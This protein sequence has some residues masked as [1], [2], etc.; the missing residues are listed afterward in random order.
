MSNRRTPRFALLASS[1]TLA[2]ALSACGGG[3]SGGNT[4]PEAPPPTPPAPPPPPAVCE[5]GNATNKGGDLPCTYRYNGQGDNIL[6]PVNADLAHEAGFTG[7][8]V[9]VG[10][11]DDGQVEGYSALDG[12]VS[13]YRDYTGKADEADPS[14]KYGHGA[15]VAAILGGN[16]GSNFNG[17]VAPDADLHWARICYDD[18]CMS[19]RAGAAVADM[20]EAGVRLFN[21]S[22]GGGYV[23]EASAR[24]SAAAWARSMGDVLSNDALI[25]HSAG[26]ESTD[27]PGNMGHVPRFFPEFNRNWL[28]VAAVDVD[29]DGNPADLSDYSNACG[30]AAEWCVVAPGRVNYPSIPDTMWTGSGY[31]TSFA[32]PIVTGT[33]A[34]VWQAFPWMSASNVQQTILTTATDLGEAG[35]DPIYGWGMVNADKA[36]RGPGQFFGSHF[37]ANVSSGSYEFANDIAGD[38]GLYKD[39]KGRLTLTGDNT[40]SGET[41]V[42]DGQLVVNNGTPGAAEVY[43]GTLTIGGNVGGDFIAGADGTTEIAIGN[44]LD[45]DGYAVLDGTLRLLNPATGYEPGATETLLT[46]VGVD[47]EFA[48]VAFGSGFFWN[49]TVDYS[50]TEVVASLERA[51]AQAV[52]MS[53]GSAQRVIEGAGQADALLGFLDAAGT[54]DHAALA[55]AAARLA[56]AQTKAEAEAALASLTGEVHGTAR[57]AAM[58]QAMS[59]SLLFGDR[60]ANLTQADAGVW[61][62]AS[63]FDGEFDRDGFATADVRQ[64]GLTVGVDRSVGES[65]VIGLALSTGRGWG[66]LDALGGRFDSDNDAVTAY[67]R[68]NLPTGYLAASA[69]FGRNKVDARRAVLLAGEAATVASEHEDDVVAA[70]LEVGVP[71]GSITPFVA[72]GHVRHKQGGFTESGADGLGLTA[73]SNTASIH[74]GEAGVRFFRQHDRVSLFGTLAGRWVGGDTRPTYAAAFAGA[75]DAGVEIHGQRVPG[76]AYRGA[77]GVEYTPVRNM[78]WN[79]SVGGETGAGDSSNAY[80]T[81]GLRIAF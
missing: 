58:S 17:G 41:I 36:V 76:N 61:V 79:V 50:A 7:N 48:E 22:L 9:K 10:V 65:G 71:L 42:V 37:E 40:Y 68:M 5:D 25:V 28:T 35:V 8:G 6:V 39:G 18:A 57:A 66:D 16:D 62:Q 20:A 55:A 44:P 38:S 12:R 75:P 56:G 27:H 11:L 26:N 60:I 59:D 43:G 13:W 73:G 53:A 15:A 69:S 24:N 49:A 70:R 47:G 31:G 77:I 3:G 78:T 33:A 63:T 30:F 81:G 64:S 52:A 45:V 2:L 46:A 1:I 72:G 29:S 34:L 23:D 32:A 51:S 21:L 4:R 14:E 80:L 74:Y 19:S 67:G 54:G